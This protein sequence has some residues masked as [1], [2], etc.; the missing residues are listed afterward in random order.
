METLESPGIFEKLDS[1]AC[2][3]EMRAVRS[4]ESGAM[5]RQAF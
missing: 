1:R 5:M 4:G 2:G 3:T